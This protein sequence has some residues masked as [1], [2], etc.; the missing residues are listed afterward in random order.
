M[1]VWLVCQLSLTCSIVQLAIKCRMHIHIPLKFNGKSNSQIIVTIAI[2]TVKLPWLSATILLAVEDDLGAVKTV[3]ADIAAKWK[4]LGLSLGIRNCDLDAIQSSSNPAAS[5]CLREMLAL[6]LK[7]NYSVSTPLIA[8]CP[9]NFEQLYVAKTL[10][11]HAVSTEGINSQLPTIPQ[12]FKIIT[13]KCTS[14]YSMLLPKSA[15]LMFAATSLKVGKS[16]RSMHAGIIL[17]HGA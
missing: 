6:W 2:S 1:A 5:D 15:H 17:E 9:L 13:L 4:D 16:W 12:K 11:K 7:Q 10:L 8:P 14:T 3:V